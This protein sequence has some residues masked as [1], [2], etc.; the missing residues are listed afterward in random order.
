MTLIL[1]LFVFSFIIFLKS[2]NKVDVKNIDASLS[3]KHLKIL[4]SNEKKFDLQ[5]KKKAIQKTLK[6]LI[7]NES[8]KCKKWIV[9]TTIQKPTRDVK[10]IHDATSPE[11]C[12][13][14]VAD[15]KSPANWQYKSVIYLSVEKQIEWENYFNVTIFF[16]Y[17]TQ[18]IKNNA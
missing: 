17:A 6:K 12:T 9:I 5:L 4:D 13:V 14:V 16:N 8:E 15:K 10:Y 2:I 7:V 18:L 11:W 1:F 3:N